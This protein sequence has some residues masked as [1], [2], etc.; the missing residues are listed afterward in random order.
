MPLGGGQCFSPELQTIQQNLSE[1]PRKPRDPLTAP[2]APTNMGYCHWPWCHQEKGVQLT[3]T[4]ILISSLNC[5][6]VCRV[7]RFTGYL[8]NK[9][10][11]NILGFSKS[12]VNFFPLPHLLINQNS[13]LNIFFSFRSLKQFLCCFWVSNLLLGMPRWP[14]L[15]TV[16]MRLPFQTHL[17]EFLEHS[18]SGGLKSYTDMTNCI[19]F[20]FELALAE[21]IQLIISYLSLWGRC[22]EQ[23]LLNSR[24]FLHGLFSVAHQLFRRCIFAVIDLIF[25]GV[26]LS[27]PGMIH[28][29]HLLTFLL[30]FSS[31]LCFVSVFLWCLILH[32]FKGFFFFKNV[33][34]NNEIFCLFHYLCCAQLIQ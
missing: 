21:F 3:Q 29:L 5:P 15:P 28:Q 30:R 10:S 16:F 8:K 11:L 12:T 31:L 25:K 4:L 2:P 14:G 23:A 27:F 24:I 22:L 7:C 18:V 1:R 26:F 13:R 33:N 20:H 19:C 34:K 17:A 6:L 9:R 32:E